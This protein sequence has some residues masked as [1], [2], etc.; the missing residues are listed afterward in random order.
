MPAWEAV[1]KRRLQA[2][3]QRGPGPGKQHF[4]QQIQGHSP[5]HRQPKKPRLPAHAP[6]G[7]PHGD[8]HGQHAH[9]QGVAGGGEGQRQP[10]ERRGGMGVQKRQNLFITNK[11]ARLPNVLG[12]IHK[13]HPWQHQP[14]QQGQQHQLVDAQGMAQAG[15]ERF[16]HEAVR[17]VLLNTALRAQRKKRMRHASTSSARRI[18]FLQKPPFYRPNSS[19]RNVPGTTLGR[20][21]GFSVVGAGVEP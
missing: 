21:R 9:G 2:L 15:P 13:H 3:P 4:H 1:V 14:G 16:G 8:K 19:T 6:H 5:A 18:F 12:H 11:A 7:Q 17:S 10:V 20:G